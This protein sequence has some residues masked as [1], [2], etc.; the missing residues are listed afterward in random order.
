MRYLVHIKISV[1]LIT[2][3]FFWVSLIVN[4]NYMSFCVSTSF[5]SL[6]AFDIKDNVAFIGIKVTYL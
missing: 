4:C 3:S 2:S 1:K 5:G 6:D